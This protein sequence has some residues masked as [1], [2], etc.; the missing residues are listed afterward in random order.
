MA[1]ILKNTSGLINTR[2]TDTG[3]EKMSQGSF[4]ISYFQIGDSEISYNVIS[5]FD[6]TNTVIL[7]PSFNSANSAPVPSANVQNIK[8]PYYVDGNAGSTYGI[9]FMDSVVSNV[10]NVAPM[11]GF[12]SANTST[13]PTNWYARTG[14]EYV[15]TPNFE[16]EINS[17]SYN[18]NTIRSEEHTSELQSPVR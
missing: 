9:P 13:L 10:Y 16:V 12:F 2:I 8:Y 4:N 7:E 5:N 17:L 3:R 1:Y 14:S 18:Q 11:R 6:Q 15:K